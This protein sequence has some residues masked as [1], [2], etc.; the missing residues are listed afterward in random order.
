[1]EKRDFKTGFKNVL[2]VIELKE[3]KDRL[4]L[5]NYKRGVYSLGGS[6]GVGT[7]WKQFTRGLFTGGKFPERIPYKW[8]EK[9]QI[10]L[11]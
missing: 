11:R 2:K 9:K 5:M 3:L 10:F 4:A 7:F 6:H 8:L 1:M